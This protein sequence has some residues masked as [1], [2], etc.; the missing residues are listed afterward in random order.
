MES[1]SESIPPWEPGLRCSQ[2]KEQC[3]I[4]IAE[5]SIPGGLFL[6]NIQ[7]LH[8][9][10]TFFSAPI[11]LNIWKFSL[12]EGESLVSEVFG[13]APSETEVGLRLEH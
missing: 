6:K 13:D 1:H 12:P 9:T 7:K 2:A 11:R 5:V 4:D 8:S 10:L 3:R